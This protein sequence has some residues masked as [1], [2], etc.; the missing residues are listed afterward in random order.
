MTYY[1][2]V[3]IDSGVNVEN[4]AQVHGVCI[5]NNINCT[6][7]DLSDKIGH[8]TIIYSIINKQI[9]SS[10]IYV[11]KLSEKNEL[12]DASLIEALK[13]VKQN[14]N[15]KIINMSL[16][17]KTGDNIN[18]LKRLCFEIADRGT[19]IVSAFDNEGC[20]SYPA[21]FEC[22]IGVDTRGDFNSSAEFDYV[23]NSAINIFAKGNVQRVMLPEGKPL[24]VNGSSIACAHITSILANVKT[25]S[26]NLQYAL[27][28]LKANSRSVFLSNNNV[29]KNSMHV[30]DINNA[31]VFPFAKEAHAFLRFADMLPFNIKS[32]YDIRRSGKV[33]KKLSCYYENDA[34]GKVIMDIDKIN[35]DGVD[36]IILGHLDEL[37]HITKRNYRTELIQKAIAAHVNIYSFD[38]LNDYSYLLENADIKYYF[39]QVNG[40][41]LPHNSF[42]K[43]YKIQKP[44]V[45]IFGTSSQQ[46]KFSLQLALKRE[47]ESLGYNVGSVGTEPHSPLFKFDV[48]FPMGYNSTVYLQNSE[49]ISFLNNEINNLC[50]KDKE[51]ILTATQA[52]IVPFYCNNLLE[53]PIL[54]YYF[55][56]GTNPDAVVLCVNFHDEIQYVKNS[57]YALKGLTNADII[58]LVMYPVTYNSDWNGL[59]GFSKHKITSQEF[60]EKANILEKEFKIPVFMLGN[61]QHMHELCQIIIDFF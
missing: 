4:Y 35:F 56:L 39:P 34:S 55:A 43:L 50:L 29:S 44:V 16:G 11:I 59:L 57:I 49:I 27:S 58:S 38:P 45:G 5:D 25:D 53:Y 8:G 61:E 17:I 18:E 3:I 46:G 42:G 52:Q 13:Y 10:K 47:L 32:Y 24:L 60:Q 23:E 20:Y 2:V 15:C 41:N 28:F 51:I 9:D 30:F 36:A 31:V 37:C 12:T 7:D 19:V 21:A 54:Q 33:G 48:V 14:I 1:D 6:N 22:V 26:F 40:Q